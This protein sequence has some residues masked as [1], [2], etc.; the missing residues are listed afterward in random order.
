MEPEATAQ[1]F[2]AAEPKERRE[3]TI[4]PFPSPLPRLELGLVLAPSS[5]SVGIGVGGGSVGM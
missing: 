5:S 3:W 1:R 2:K 4:A